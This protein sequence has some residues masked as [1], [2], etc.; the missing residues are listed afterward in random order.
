MRTRFPQTC[1]QR[2]E[3]KIMATQ[4]IVPNIWCNGNAEEV[5][6]FY[7]GAFAN[8]TSEVESRYPHTGLLDF[9]KTFAGQPLT[10]AVTISGYRF[11]L[12]N[13]GPEFAPNPTIS[14][15]LNFDPLLFDSDETL[16]RASLTKLW[17]QLSEGGV[18]LMPLDE[19]PFSA[20]SGWVQDRHG[21]SWQ[22][23]LT[24]PAGEPRP[25]ILPVLMFG[26]RVQNH[27]GEAVGHY[28]DVFAD[29]PGGSE[30]GTHVL[31]A[32]PQGPAEPGAI[33]FS[34][35]RL[36]EQWFLAMD[37]ATEMK[38][39]F[40]NGVSF[41]VHCEDQNEIDQLWDSL[42]AVPESEQCGWLKDRFG[43]SWQI[44]PKHMNELMQLPGAFSRML[45]MKKLV[46]ADFGAAERR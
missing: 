11:T 38:E 2:L 33:Q 7:A 17:Q 35:F 44:V 4:R 39:T 25:F 28:L 10:V 16:A 24:D 32:E 12:I 20:L 40:T 9:Q 18:V 21:V 19:Y 22:L 30:L 13:A 31:Y 36:G 42:S 43:V 23:M 46:I 41:E 45:D 3:G 8:A 27:A 6:S 34:D 29:L 15:M 37:A 14:F 5:G 26:N 1:W